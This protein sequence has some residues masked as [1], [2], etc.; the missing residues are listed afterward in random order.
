MRECKNAAEYDNNDAMLPIIAKVSCM[1]ELWEQ[2]I[3]ARD[4][5]TDDAYP[6]RTRQDLYPGEMF[7]R[8]ES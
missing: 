5:A 1:F 2:S 4:T 6:V 8:G 7:N 3:I